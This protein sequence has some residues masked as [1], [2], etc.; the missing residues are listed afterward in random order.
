MATNKTARATGG[1][2][3]T[4]QNYNNELVTSIADLEDKR[5]ELN[6]LILKDEEERAK[7]QADLAKLNDR[8]ERVN[9]S[10]AAK[11]K[12]R[13]EYEQAIQDSKAAYMKVVGS[14]T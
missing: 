12:A 11:A 14:S 2:A 4:L 3:P 1:G 5:D 7:I 6:M 9:E 13:D 10:R 8:L